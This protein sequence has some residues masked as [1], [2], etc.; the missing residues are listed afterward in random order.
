M[1][2]MHG[3]RFY[4][5]VECLRFS[6]GGCGPIGSEGLEHGM[7]LYHCNYMLPNKTIIYIYIYI[8][9]YILIL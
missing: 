9:I 5:L 7:F 4:S 8:Y 3:P 2:E 1:A 6:S